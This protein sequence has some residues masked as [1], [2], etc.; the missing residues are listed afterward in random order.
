MLVH[1]GG[2]HIA[3]TIN[4]KWWPESGGYQQ[5]AEERQSEHPWGAKNEIVE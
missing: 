2:R 4:E 1:E 5:S 3:I